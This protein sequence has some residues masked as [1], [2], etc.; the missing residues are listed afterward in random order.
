MNKLL[1]QL[2][3]VLDENGIQVKNLNIGDVVNGEYSIEVN[4]EINIVDRQGNYELYTKD[5]SLDKTYYSSLTEALEVL[6]DYLSV[7]KEGTILKSGNG[8]YTYKVIKH[9]INDEYNLLDLETDR[10]LFLEHASL[11][12][13]KSQVREGVFCVKEETP[14]TDIQVGDRVKVLKIEA[15]AEGEATVTAVL[16]DGNVELEG[17]GQ[18]GIYL[19]NWSNHI[20]NIEKIE[21]CDEQEDDGLLGYR[22]WY[23]D[24]V[25]FNNFAVLKAS[26]EGYFETSMGKRYTYQ[27]VSGLIEP[28]GRVDVHE[29]FKR[30]KD[31]ESLLRYYPEVDDFATTY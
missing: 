21:S 15:G 6:A 17:I 16:E 24:N 29:E 28:I 4:K 10:L 22:Y 30:A 1:K 12:L 3:Q 31:K 8:K 13:I 25:V 18:D 20:S 2:I 5:A 26:L 23:L 27:D 9:Q 19:T 7:V 11:S 14:S